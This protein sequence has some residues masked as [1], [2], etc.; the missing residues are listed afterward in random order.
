MFF[1]LTGSVW[2][3]QSP[4]Y[5]HHIFIYP[6]I[7]AQLGVASISEQLPP[8]PWYTAED[9]PQHREFRAILFANSVWVLLRPT[10]LRTSS[11]EGFQD[12]ACCLSSLSEKTRESHQLQMTL[13]RQHFL[14]GS[15]K[16]LSVGFAVVELTGSPMAARCSTNSVPSHRCGVILEMNAL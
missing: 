2:D 11:V 13:Q 9:R 14:L 15:L 6:R 10:E 16:T 8:H 4:F 3:H 7:L 5:H 1:V 12:G